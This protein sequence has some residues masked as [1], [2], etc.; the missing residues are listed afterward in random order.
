MRSYPKNNYLSISIIINLTIFRIYVR[1][2]RGRGNHFTAHSFLTS[3]CDIYLSYPQE[4][5]RIL[6]IQNTISR[7][8]GPQHPSLPLV[9]RMW[10]RCFALDFTSRGVQKVTKMGHVRS[11]L[12]ARDFALLCVNLTAL[13]SARNADDFQN[14]KAI[15][16]PQAHQNRISGGE[17]FAPLPLPATPLRRTERKRDPRPARSRRQ[18]K[19]EYFG[20]P[21]SHPVTPPSPSISKI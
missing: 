16:P 4:V 2:F 18:N 9:R 12:A 14:P 19:S 15:I 5:F 3:S 21:A 7:N 6:L 13:P 20:W 1:F 11:L 8:I 17:S 10:K